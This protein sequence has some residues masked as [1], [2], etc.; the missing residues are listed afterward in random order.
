[1]ATFQL[2]RK[3]GNDPQALDPD[4]TLR[5]KWDLT[6]KSTALI[7]SPYNLIIKIESENL[8]S[9]QNFRILIR[10]FSKNR[11][12]IQLSTEN[13]IRIQASTQTVP[14][15]IWDQNPRFWIRSPAIE[16]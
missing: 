2:Y 9:I 1:M 8:D 13:Q 5:E 12:R 7:L 3:L 14:G 6:W 16:I 15:S 10:A 11:T 4:P